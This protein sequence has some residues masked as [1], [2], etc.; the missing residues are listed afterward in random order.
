MLK[1]TGLPTSDEIVVAS[2]SGG[3]DSTAMCLYLKELGIQYRAVHML[4]GWDHQETID[5]IRGP[6]TQAIGPIEEIGYEG[7]MIAMLREKKMFPTGSLR[8]C[9][10]ELKIKPMKALIESILDSGFEVVNAV[11]V[12]REESEE[13]ST[14]EEWIKT[15]WADSWTWSPLASWT[16]QDVVDIHTRHGIRPNPLYLKGVQRVGCWP[17]IFMA[18]DEIRLLAH[19][20]PKRIDL[21]DE[22]E[23]ELSEGAS[24]RASAKGK[25][26]KYR[27]FFSHS[28]KQK[29]G[30]SKRIPVPIRSA[31]QWSMTSRGGRQFEMFTAPSRDAGCMRWGLCDT[32][33]K[34]FEV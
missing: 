22:L 11:G 3:K 10:E 2:V 31:V 29:D 16:F 18:K 27:T 1:R 21:L 19:L 14:T 8:F 7:G 24:E 32:G 13:R 20:D 5:Y 9:T 34:K 15:E 23:K 33:A 12:R 26:S 17:C 28:K 25:T 6:L 30:K 4:T